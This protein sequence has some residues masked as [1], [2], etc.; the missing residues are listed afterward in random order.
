MGEGFKKVGRIT[1][2]EVLLILE[3][4]AG[5]YS[6]GLLRSEAATLVKRLCNEQGLILTEWFEVKDDSI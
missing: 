2:A 3:M 1:R 4:A 6:E 5:C